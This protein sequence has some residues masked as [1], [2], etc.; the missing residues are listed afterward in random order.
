VAV[1][2]YRSLRHNVTLNEKEEALVTSKMT[3]Q[4]GNVLENKG[5][6]SD[7]AG[8]SGNLIES[9]G[10]YAPKAGM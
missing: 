3:E 7:A 6:Q 1:C 5:P 10:S 8:R 9:K 4:G 2:P